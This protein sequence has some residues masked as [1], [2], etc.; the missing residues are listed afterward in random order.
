MTKLFDM[1]TIDAQELAL[2]YNR[3]GAKFGK[4]FRHYM[5]ELPVLDGDRFWEI[6]EK[7]FR[8]LVVERITRQDAAKDAISEF[9]R[10][11]SAAGKVQVWDSRGGYRY[12]ECPYTFDEAL[13][14]AKTWEHYKR[15][16][17]KP[18]FNVVEDKGDDGYGDLLD[19]LPLAG[20]VVHNACHDR[21]YGDN[22]E[23]REAVKNTLE[24]VVDTQMK[25]NEFVDDERIAKVKKRL[26][27][28][29][30]DG[31][32]YFEMRLTD[33]AQSW[34]VIWARDQYLAEQEK[35]GKDGNEVYSE[36]F[37]GF[38]LNI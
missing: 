4:A 26:V 35:E 17:Y 15:A 1:E 8:P 11:Q 13:R 5:E 14:F 33:I 31:E 23:F 2:E 34:F 22:E 36:E 30:I 10:V 6:L 32:N 16:L 29:V 9:F 12:E 20:Q 3:V 25:G 24:Q 19:S 28:F 21:D 37:S 38:D 18:L 7:Y 27:S